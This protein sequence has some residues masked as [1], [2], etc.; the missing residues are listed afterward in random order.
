M[1][2]FGIIEDPR[3]TEEGAALFGSVAALDE[4]I[5]AVKWALCRNLTHYP[6][7]PGTRGLRVAEVGGTTAVAYIFYTEDGVRATLKTILE[8]P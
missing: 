6:M 1:V 7:I 3:F 8:A 2:G 5:D 4:M